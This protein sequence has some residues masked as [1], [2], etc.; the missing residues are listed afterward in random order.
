[1]NHCLSRECRQMCF[2]RGLPQIEPL[3]IHVQRWRP[4]TVWSSS[5]PHCIGPVCFCSTCVPTKCGPCT[6]L[7]KTECAAAA[8][9]AAVHDRAARGQ[10]MPERLCAVN[11]ECAPHVETKRD[12]SRRQA[13]AQVAADEQQRV[14]RVVFQRDWEWSWFS[15]LVRLRR[16]EG[17]TRQGG[18]RIFYCLI[19]VRL[20]FLDL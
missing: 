15:R 5:I 2:S 16:M 10:E 6:Q 11:L 1:M 17:W 14:S 20:I 13:A 12:A 3:L 8:A 9:G 4:V 19:V 7:Q 18:G